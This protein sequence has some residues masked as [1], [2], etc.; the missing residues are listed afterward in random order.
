MLINELEM[1]G[2]T[3]TMYDK[4]MEKME[5]WSVEDYEK[6][7]RKYEAPFLEKNPQFNEK[8]RISKE[9]MDEL[10]RKLFVNSADDFVD[11][12]AAVNDDLV[13]EGLNEE[14]PLEIAEKLNKMVVGVLNTNKDDI[15]GNTQTIL[16]ITKNRFWN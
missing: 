14:I 2:I 12:Y 4:V 8:G 3:E 10:L 5:K 11:Y 6:V 7:K 13:A 15:V 1:H 9:G 16:P